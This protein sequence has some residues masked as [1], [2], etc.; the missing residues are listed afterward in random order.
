MV[1]SWVTA[2]DDSLVRVRSRPAR[3]A[4][5]PVVGQLAQRAAQLGD[6]GLDRRKPLVG[7]ALDAAL[8][9]RAQHE[10]EAVGVEHPALA[11]DHHALGDPDQQRPHIVGRAVQ[12]LIGEQ[13]VQRAADRVDVE[14]GVDR[15]VHQRLIDR[16]GRDRPA[17]RAEDPALV[18]GAVGRVPRSSSDI[19]RSK[20]NT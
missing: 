10:R 8:D 20:S 7:I 13:P 18:V 15:R 16:L 3:L 19:A 4:A 17:R 6:H 1:G 12:Q 11:A 5:R 14:R 9:R 2:T